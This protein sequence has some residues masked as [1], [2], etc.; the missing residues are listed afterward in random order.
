ME[1]LKSALADML[2]ASVV[3]DVIYYGITLPSSDKKSLGHHLS[4]TDCGYELLLISCGFAKKLKNGQV[5][6][7]YNNW[8]SFLHLNLPPE[9]FSIV[10]RQYG[11]ITQCKF[12]KTGQFDES[13][14]MF[15]APGKGEQEDNLLRVRNIS[16]IR[17]KFRLSVSHVLS[18]PEHFATEEFTDNLPTTSK[19]IPSDSFDLPHLAA[20][21]KSATTDDDK[22]TDDAVL[23]AKDIL[24]ATINRSNNLDNLPPSKS[25]LTSAGSEH[26]SAS[27]PH[28][29][30]RLVRRRQVCQSGAGGA[31]L[32]SF[33]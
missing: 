7:N 16:K 13:K 12:L 24:A 29:L 11:T 19:K 25:S 26:Q 27:P 20:Q 18:S 6:N 8:D 21:Q 17:K 32:S 30:Q 2:Q 22:H 28:D 23:F 3:R 1:S 15:N 4:L 31:T 5:R 9:D 33:V 10:Q 14:G